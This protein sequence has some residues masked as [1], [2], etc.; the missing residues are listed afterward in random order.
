MKKDLETARTKYN[1]ACEK[2]SDAFYA[3]YGG[4][5]A[6]CFKAVLGGLHIPYSIKQSEAEL[7]VEQGK[8]PEAL[9]SPA[10]ESKE[11]LMERILL[12]EAQL[13]DAITAANGITSS[14]KAQTLK[15]LEEAQKLNGQAKDECPT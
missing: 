9:N 1:K 3:C 8:M 7:L 6:W 2:C 4:S 5:V 13:K 11:S 15:L 10:H 12:L 14:K